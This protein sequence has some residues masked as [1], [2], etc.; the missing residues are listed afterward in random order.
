MAWLDGWSNRLEYVIDHTR[1]DAD[2]TNFPVLLTLSSG[3]GL[4]DFDATIVFDE[5]SVSGSEYKI[6]VTDSSGSNQL[7]VEIEFWDLAG[8]EAHLWTKVPT[9]SSGT[10]TKLYLYYDNA[11]VD[12]TVFV[13]YATSSPAS[14]V[15]DSNYLQVI[16]MSQNPSISNVLDS[17][18][19]G[20]YAAP[21]GMSSSDL[22]DNRSIYFDGTNNYLDLRVKQISTNI[23]VECVC[24]REANNTNFAIFDCQRAGSL[25]PAY[26]FVISSADN[27]PRF[28][29]YTSTSVKKEIVSSVVVGT[30]YNYMAGIYNYST[31]KVMVDGT[32]NSISET[33]TPN[34]INHNYW[35]GASDGSSVGYYN[36][37]TAEYRLSN[38]ARSEAWLNATYYS[39]FDNLLT[40]T[41]PTV[42]TASGTVYVDSSLTDGI[43]V[44][45]YRRF[46]GQLVGETT[47]TSGGLFEIDTP[48]DEEHYI[49]A[50][51]TTSGTN[52][53]VYDWIAP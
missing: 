51:Y 40:V 6:A 46:D 23:T 37:Y 27:K 3:S 22:V 41:P 19:N 1:I 8:E 34:N 28:I 50:F 15:W 24:K 39:V 17:T 2:L 21:T 42:F 44:R 12:N 14:Q 4:T 35:M 45:L 25:W 48:Y 30:D 26:Y 9:V 18:S 20:T 32:V 13:G 5:L 7:Y 52:A 16:H 29:F 11:H 38:T 33:T 36:G 10:N 31:L 53:L 47:T 43:S 49:L